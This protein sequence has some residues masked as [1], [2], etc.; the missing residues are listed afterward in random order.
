MSDR[1]SFRPRA[2]AA[3]GLALVAALVFASAVLTGTATVSAQGYTTCPSGVYVPP[4]GYC[5]S[6]GSGVSVVYPGQACPTPSPTYCPVPYGVEPYCQSAGSTVTYPAGW[7]IVGG[8][9]GTTE[10]GSAGPLYGF[11]PGSVSYQTLPQGSPLQAGTGYW[12]YF[13]TGA[14]VALA[15]GGSGTS[16]INLPPGQFTLIGNPGIG[17][18]TV[19]GANA[20]L[21]VWSPTTGSYEET[22]QL[23]AGQGAWA[24]S[25]TGGPLTIT[26]S[27][28]LPPGPPF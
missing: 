21:F 7:N 3:A 9:A 15:A 17:T 20:A 19:S 14:T 8:P 16:T 28:G 10:T 5:C 25:M 18:A 12:A 23:A 4:G 13:S 1:K 11:P 22:N 26:S 2:L 6:N 27:P 24:I